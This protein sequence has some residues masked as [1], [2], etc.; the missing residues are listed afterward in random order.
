M[1]DSSSNSH[2]VW[3]GKSTNG[4][5]CYCKSDAEACNKF[6]KRLK[7][8]MYDI[9]HD[10]NL[11]E[12]R[13]GHNGVVFDGERGSVYKV[14]VGDKCTNYAS[15]V[16]LSNSHERLLPISSITLFKKSGDI[17][18]TIHF[19]KP[20][21]NTSLSQRLL[22]C[23][24]PF[25]NTRISDRDVDLVT[26]CAYFLN[27]IRM[28]CDLIVTTMHM[29]KAVPVSTLDTEDMNKYIQLCEDLAKEHVI[30]FD[31]KLNNVV[32]YNGNMRFID[33][34]EVCKCQANWRLLLLIMLVHTAICDSNM[35]N[36]LMQYVKRTFDADELY[37]LPLL[38]QKEFAPYGM[39]SERI[40]NVYRY[41]IAG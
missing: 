28:N 41:P 27:Q 38:D 8:R 24:H 31:A 40:Y 19:K 30:Q 20:S 11:S 26:D 10:I 6:I 34:D 9:N 32:K 17:I 33:L 35:R 5:K 3:F 29:P 15:L 4:E 7:Q 2:I 39:N 21:K 36:H 25:K 23:I 22:K 14:Q 37:I 16:Q 12:Y 1:Y 13:C 18:E